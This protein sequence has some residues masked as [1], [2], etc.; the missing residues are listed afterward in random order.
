MRERIGSFAL[1]TPRQG[2]ILTIIDKML[3]TSCRKTVYLQIEHNNTKELAMSNAT[4]NTNKG[5]DQMSLIEYSRL[6]ETK[7][8]RDK[9]RYGVWSYH[10]IDKQTRGIKVQ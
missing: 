4:Q 10:V 2:T 1:R 3:L 7:V 5:R 6:I 8:Q 9:K